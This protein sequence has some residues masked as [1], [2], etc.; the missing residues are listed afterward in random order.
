MFNS[1]V[2]LDITSSD[3]RVIAFNN[4]K[5]VKWGSTSLAEGMVKDGIISDPEAVGV[6]IDSLFKTYELNRSQ[7]ICTLTG[8]PFL[9]R[10]IDMPG[11]IS[12]VPDE[13][14]Q[15]AA[16]K[17]MSLI[18]EEICLLWQATGEV[19]EEE[20]SYFVL[21]IP[22]A[23][24]NP[25][26][27]TLKVA[28]IKPCIIDLKPLAVARAASVSNACIVSLERNYFDIV[29]VANGLVRVIHSIS[30]SSINPDDPIAIV[31]ELADGFNKAVKS[32]NRDFPQGAFGP[33]DPILLSGE[34]A[35]NADVPRMIQDST[36]HPASILNP[37][38]DVPPE[39][40][41]G[42]Y[43][44]S[45]G[46]ILKKYRRGVDHN[47]Y[48][49]ININ[50]LDGIY[51]PTSVRNPL[52]YAG[53][54]VAIVVL[55]ILAFQAYSLKA[56]AGERVELLKLESARVTQRI[57]DLQDYNKQVQE[58]IQANNSKVQ[59]LQTELSALKNDNEMVIDKKVDFASQYVS[60]NEAMLNT[61]EY[62]QIDMDSDAYT[63]FG[64][65]QEIHDI[66]AFAKNLEREEYFGVARVSEI[67]P[68]N[69]ASTDVKFTIEIAR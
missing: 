4:N 11:G 47:L 55:A 43:A 15:R 3:I 45:I 9:Y 18:G 24:F 10:H 64:T 59:N 17:E 8:L 69:D 28:K 22:K 53:A 48:H 42:Q 46:L 40:P 16:K 20:T 14:I 61:I 13:A 54:G 68:I 35:L 63:I 12:K 41:S 27:E 29:L 62:Q 38:I 36:G 5:I 67:E 25:L 56:D 21:G 30:P 57:N 33:E 19:T 7:V 26:L 32:F 34:L 58:D 60:I 6:I 39:M 31:A 49:D 51:K 52:I 50:L 44:A 1:Y 65:S 23:S 2:A 66:F 37:L